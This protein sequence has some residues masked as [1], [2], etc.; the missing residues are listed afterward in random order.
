MAFGDTWHLRSRARECAATG[1]TFTSGQQII[2]AIFPDPD[3]SGYLRKDFSLEGWN[4]L[5]DDAEK[6]FSF[7]KTSFVST[8]AAE[9][10]AAE[11]LSAEEILRRLI[12]EDED[13]T[14]NTRYILAVML[15][16]QKLLRETDSQRTAGGIIR[17]Y[18]H[19]K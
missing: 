12:E 15:E 17:V 19:K 10:P 9:K 8:A 13:H 5:A 3:S 14:E 4:G 16:R 11:K 1:T 18:E 2:T 7:W 6:P